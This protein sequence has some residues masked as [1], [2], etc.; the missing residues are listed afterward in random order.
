MRLESSDLAGER[1][2]ALKDLFPEVFTEGRID[3]E[4]LR[5]ALGDQVDTGRERYGLTW[6]SAWMPCTCRCP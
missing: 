4:K 2:A 1:K 6:A 5:L 3:F